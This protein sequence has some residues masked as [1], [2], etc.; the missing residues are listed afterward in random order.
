MLYTTQ[1]RPSTQTA[2]RYG[3]LCLKRGETSKAKDAFQYA[4]NRSPRNP[5][6]YYKLGFAHERLKNYTQAIEAYNRATLLGDKNPAISFR[7]ARTLAAT[8]QEDAAIAHYYRAISNNHLPQQAYTAIYTLEANAPMWKRLQTLREGAPYCHDDPQW[9]TSRAVLA[10]KMGYP[11]EAIDEFRAAEAIKQLTTS[12]KVTLSL[13]L[14]KVGHDSEANNLLTSTAA[15]DN[16]RPA[17]IGPGAYLIDRGHWKGAINLLRSTLKSTRDAKHRADIQFEIGHAFDRQYLWQ[18][19]ESWF[20]TSL[21]SFDQIAYRHYR[22][23]VTLERSGSYRD[24]FGPYA[25]A[26]QL[27]PNRSH[28]WYRLGEAARKAGELEVAHEALQQS[29]TTSDTQISPDHE[30]EHTRFLHSL[31]STYLR[32]TLRN[33]RQLWPTD[34]RSWNAEA[35]HY[36]KE[37]D[38]EAAAA[39]YSEIEYRTA[40][41]PHNVLSNFSKN[42]FESGD[43]QIAL[44]ALSQSRH[45]R[46]PDGLNLSTH[47]APKTRRC[48][49]LFAQFMDDLPLDE[50]TVLFESNHG[51]SIG[52]HPLALFR[53]MLSDPRFDNFRFVWSYTAEAEVPDEVSKNYRVALAEIHSDLYLKHL[54]TAKFLVNNVT[55]PPYYLR[56]DGQVYMNTWHGTPLKTLGRSMRQ[57]LLEYENIARNFA[58]ATHI[59]APNSLTKWA[60]L[61]EHRIDRYATAAIKLTGSPRLDRLVSDHDSLRDQVRSMLNIL[62]DEHV[63]L[64]APTWR[65]GVSDRTF[66]TEQL[67]DDLQAMSSIDG[68]KVLFRAHRLT[69]SLVS[70]LDLPVETVPHTLDT[71]DLLAGVD[72]LITDYSS[73]GFDFLVTH[74]RLI[75]YVPDF[76]NYTSSRGLYLEY[77]EF[78]GYVCETRTELVQLLESETPPSDKSANAIARFASHEDGQ[79]S[80]RAVNF[81][82]EPPNARSSSRPTIVIHASLI[83][84]GIASALLSLLEHLDPDQISVVLVVEASVM[85]REEDRQT[86]LHRLPEYVN[87]AF[88]IGDIVATAEEQWAVGRSYSADITTSQPLEQLTA[89]AWRRDARRTL[90]SFAPSVAIEF[91]GYASLWSS[92]IA[93]VGD[94]KTRRFIWQHN[95]LVQEWSTKY[96]ELAAV[97]RLYKLYDG[98]VSVSGSLMAENKEALQRAG[99]Q[100]SAPF[101]AVPNVLDSDRIHTLAE[102]P[103]DPDL[104][105]WFTAPGPI[106][107]SVGRLSPE[108]NFLSLVESWPQVIEQHPQARLVII[109]D[110]ILRAALET[111]ISQLNLTDSIKLTGQRENPYSHMKRADLFVL[112]STHEGQPVV[113]FEAMSL[114]VP[115]AAAYTP[116]TKEALETGYGE[117]ISHDAD[118]LAA[119][120]TRILTDPSVAVGQFDPIRFSES[121]V[122]HFKDLIGDTHF[123]TT[124]EGHTF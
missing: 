14:L 93:A 20:R 57:G 110:G 123:Q 36:L 102:S 63:V 21:D 55:F 121:A 111:R 51:A 7:L 80:Q 56:R 37:G 92:F 86:I 66:D 100:A 1:T 30:G 71:N 2:L 48:R 107:V 47:T 41:P 3:D 32:D 34:P 77:D 98:V 69:E 124:E 9:R 88:R 97:F 64:Y 35:E 38:K 119:D 53:T 8:G 46:F 117:L 91:D 54:A 120:I 72:T 60:I 82:M 105:S 25:C 122:R 68:V 116:G 76:E 31:T 26:L 33:R 39:L 83:P 11:F 62:P 58:Q 10:A 6:A 65:G 118:G 99:F 49:S 28:W 109:G 15:D 40:T 22:L 90:G 44:Q 114:G 23:G 106:V 61:D 17:R 12:Q 5:Q 74:N 50:K 96:P 13:Q 45:V 59:I 70:S 43:K 94:S 84:N 42:E 19:A 101:H 18:Q 95:Q 16:G 103:V 85:R 108:K 52:C 113:I 78:P 75:Y 27:E 67:L 81:L 24:S 79:A 112:P 104:A 89:T 115:T 4:A 87:L 73:I 29:L